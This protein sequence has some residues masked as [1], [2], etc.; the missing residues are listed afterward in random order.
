MSPPAPI[1]PFSATAATIT[2]FFGWSAHTAIGALMPGVRVVALDGDVLEVERV[3]LGH[4]RVEPQRRQRPRLAGQ[5]QP[6]L[7]EVVAVE[8]R[9]AE[10]VHEVADLEAGDLGDHVGQQGVRRDVERH[11]RGRRRRSAGRA[12]RTAG[13]PAT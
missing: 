7:V 3:E 1:T 11:A 9:V 10:R 4:R 2:T 12:G 5:L 8:V 13:R 6:G